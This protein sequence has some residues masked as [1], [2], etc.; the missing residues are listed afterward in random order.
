MIAGFLGTLPM[1]VVTEGPYGYRLKTFQPGTPGTL[2]ALL[3]TTIAIIPLLIQEVQRCKHSSRV[4]S[5][6]LSSRQR[7]QDYKDGLI[8]SDS[9]SFIVMPLE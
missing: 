8:Y 1:Q 5:K 2:A 7:R 3:Y 4:I 9:V 6:H